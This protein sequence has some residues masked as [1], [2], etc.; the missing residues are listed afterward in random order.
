MALPAD[1]LVERDPQHGNARVRGVKGLD[2]RLV[3]VAHETVGAE[4]NCDVG[5]RLGGWG[6]VGGIG[7]TGWRIGGSIRATGWRWL[8]GYRFKAARAEHQRSDQRQ[9]QGRAFAHGGLSP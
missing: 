3:D 8:L 9:K 6:T 5:I 1:R 7:T 2:Q 4:G